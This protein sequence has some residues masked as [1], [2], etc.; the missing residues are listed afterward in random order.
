MKEIKKAKEN[1][2][3]KDIPT[4]LAKSPVIGEKLSDL[5]LGYFIS[6]DRFTYN[7]EWD[8]TLEWKSDWKEE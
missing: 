1:D 7:Q 8:K 4:E 6:E 3:H 2:D 5:L